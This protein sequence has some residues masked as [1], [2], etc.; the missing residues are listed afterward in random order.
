MLE[1]AVFWIRLTGIVLTAL[2]L[3]A[4]SVSGYLGSRA[5]AER[6]AEN[7]QLR[8]QLRNVE[9][10]YARELEQA[11]RPKAPEMRGLSLEEHRAVVA[12]LQPL[13]GERVLVISAQE[14]EPANYAHQII[15]SLRAGGLDVRVTYYPESGEGV[16]DGLEAVWTDEGERIVEALRK[17]GIELS[18]SRGATRGGVAL[19][20]RIGR[21][22][23]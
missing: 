17:N 16:P 5:V 14:W 20:L 1:T 7:D 10:R 15:K 9:D 13:A 21:R 8:S 3:I 11:R 18:A 23:P 4:L 19:E 6:R 22:K 2:G 12:T